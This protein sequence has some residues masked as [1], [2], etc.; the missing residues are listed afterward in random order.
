VLVRI[1]DAKSLEI[2]DSMASLRWHALVCD[3]GSAKSCVEDDESEDRVGSVL[4]SLPHARETPE[5]HAVSRTV[6]R[7]SEFAPLDVSMSFL[8]MDSSARLT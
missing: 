5:R 8:S 1:G 3:G 4:S 6:S 7:L 2:G